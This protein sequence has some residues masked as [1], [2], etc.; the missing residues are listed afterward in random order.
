MRAVILTILLAAAAACGSIPASADGGGDSPDGGGQAGSVE[1]WVYDQ[2]RPAP[3][4]LVVFH[5]TDGTVMNV[6]YTDGDGRAIRDVAPGGMVTVAQT[7]TNDELRL[8]TVVGVHPGE[9]I[10]VGSRATVGPD[11]PSAGEVS[12]QLPGS[13]S[14]ASAYAIT[15]GCV[16]TF[17]GSTTAPVLLDVPLTCVGTTGTFTVF[18]AAVD[19]AQQQPLAYSLAEGTPN[20]ALTTVAMPAWRQDFSGLVVDTFN[21]PPDSTSV[22]AAVSLVVNGVPFTY[23]VQSAPI[24]GGDSA[25][26]TFLSP[27]GLAEGAR[28]SAAWSVSPES[29]ISYYVDGPAAPLAANGESMLQQ[30]GDL[31]LNQCGDPL[32]FHWST[33]ERA[34]EADTMFAALRW[35]SGGTA[36]KW[37]LF[38][39][40]EASSPFVFPELPEELAA[41]RPNLDALGPLSAGYL[42]SSTV[43]GYA[44]FRSGSSHLLEDGW[45]KGNVIGRIA[46]SGPPPF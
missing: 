10:P 7:G 8:T 2:G 40:P 45:D 16:N 17:T 4:V 18:A 13:W 9:R 23:P 35:G 14:G 19:A 15:L 37:I 42:D 1:V 6:G 30:V 33:P 11:P 24:G 25:A 36:Y 12:I 43:D 46:L 32:C 28:M 5:D 44:V 29:L 34:G 22:T 20:G 3:D 41:W 26:M 39:P 21:A 38:L 27:P 31:S